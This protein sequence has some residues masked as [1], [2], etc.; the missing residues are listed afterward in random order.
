MRALEH[1]LI[2]KSKEC[3]NHTVLYHD[4]HVTTSDIRHKLFSIKILT[5]I[6]PTPNATV[7]VSILS[8]YESSVY[9]QM[10]LL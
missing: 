7:L 2:I 6:W 4:I 1:F 3:S 8:S 5:W 10:E 9:A